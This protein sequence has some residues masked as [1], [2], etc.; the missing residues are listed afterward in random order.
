MLMPTA[1]ATKSPSARLGFLLAAAAAAVA[2]WVA[3][4]AGLG[5]HGHEDL[6]TNSGHENLVTNWLYYVVLVLAAATCLV[7]AH[8]SRAERAGWLALGIGLLCWTGADIYWTEALGDVADPPYPSLADVGYLAFYPAVWLGIALLVRERVARFTASVW[9]DGMIGAAAAVALGVAVL[10][11]AFVG[12]TNGEPAAVWSLAYPVGDLLLLAFI[13]AA[14]MLTGVRLRWLV[15][16]GGITVW[17]AADAIYLYQMAH[18]TYTGGLLDSMWLVGALLIAAAALVPLKGPAEWERENAQSIVFPA[19]FVAV[20]IGILAWDHYTRLSGISIFFAELT[21]VL[22]VVRLALS[23]RENKHL[24]TAVEAEATTDPLTG[25]PNR[26]RLLLDLDA[27]LNPPGLRP[28]EWVFAM[29]DLDGFKAYND[30]FGHSAGD[31]LLRRL[32][33]ALETATGPDVVPYRL[34]GDEF[35]ILARCAHGD[36]ESIVAAA[37]AALHETGDGFSIG[38][39]AG[40]VKLPAE[41]SEQALVL[42]LADERMYSEKGERSSSAAIQTRDVLVRILQEREPDLSAHLRG[43]AQLADVVGRAL[44]LDAK[45]LDL[46]GRAAELHDVGKIAIPDRILH[47]AG[48]PNGAEWELLREHTLIGE[49]IL[50]SAPAMLPAARLVRSSHERWDGTGYPDGL[51]GEQIPLGARIINVCDAFD[52]I[53]R[54][55]PY[56][57][58]QTGAEALAELR[59]GAGTQF[60]PEIVGLFCRTPQLGENLTAVLEPTPS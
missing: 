35:C 9:L 40:M 44:D 8:V 24:F 51:A 11:P 48:T 15:L 52:A 45:D 7:R 55:R 60:D 25:L 4:V 33:R 1:K 42:H 37:K 39:S 2:F 54:G 3:H 28:R 10:A 17:G 47:K 30:T 16:G 19:V 32:G 13:G 6:V 36:G 18:G 29:F 46:L 58:A 22:V 59:R 53:I 21:I 20:A 41:A 26:R 34:G 43:V 57:P 14:A 27:A 49:R 23:F 38:A 12:F 5:G 50:N 31:L 56:R